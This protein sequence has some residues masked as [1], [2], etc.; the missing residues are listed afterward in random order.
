[1]ARLSSYVMPLGKTLTKEMRIKKHRKSWRV[2]GKK[3]RKQMARLLIL[4][5]KRSLPYYAP[6]QVMKIA[7][8]VRLGRKLAE[9]DAWVAI[10]GWTKLR[11]V[12]APK[13]S[14]QTAW[15]NPLLRQKP[16][17]P[18]LIVRSLYRRPSRKGRPILRRKAAPLL[19]DFVGNVVLN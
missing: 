14:Q 18:K 16:P 19:S 12:P 9:N 3:S 17:L 8:S 2:N 15:M 10:F 6:F 7:P 1:M 5:R 13:R 11:L 4:I